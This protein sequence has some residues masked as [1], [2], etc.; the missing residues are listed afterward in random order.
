MTGLNAAFVVDRATRDAIVAN[1][2]GSAELLRPFLE[3][4]DTKRWRVE[5]RDLFLLYIPKN[6]LQI[7]D[8]PGAKAWLEPF[9]EKLERRATKQEWF[10]LQ[11]AQEA[12]ADRYAGPKITRAPSR[13]RPSSP[14]TPTATFRMTRP[15]RAGGRPHARAA[16]QPCD[17]VAF[18]AVARAQYFEARNR[19]TSSS[20]ST[21]WKLSANKCGTGR[22]C[23]RLREAVRRAGR[24]PAPHSDL[25]PPG[26]PK[27]PQAAGVV[28][29]AGL[30]HPAE[31]RACF[32]AD[33]PLETATT[34]RICLSVEGPSPV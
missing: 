2:P 7:G 31:V 1:D 16:Q 17:L 27:A 6:R 8:Y 12:F 25:C 21:G 9:K 24:V 15:R 19:Y 26:E 3:G 11:Q 4:K 33:I 30:L 28:G 23:Q 22:D 5:S 14:S 20:S 32:R 18:V 13:L 29:D 10:E 34:G